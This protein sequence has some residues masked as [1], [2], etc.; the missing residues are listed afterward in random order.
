MSFARLAEVV[1]F[2]AK[3]DQPGLDRRIKQA[4]MMM[5]QQHAAIIQGFA[6]MAGWQ[7]QREWNEHNGNGSPDGKHLRVYKRREI[8]PANK[9]N[10]FHSALNRLAFVRTFHCD[11][12]SNK[13]KPLM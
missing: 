5:T 2:P 6:D 3:C 13:L 12:P 1:I 4:R 10:A 9:P 11:V 7:P 8:Q